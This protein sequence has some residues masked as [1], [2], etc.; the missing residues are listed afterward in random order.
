MA[1]ERGEINP[2]A[3]P[4]APLDRAP[5]TPERSGRFLSATPA[6]RW[7][8]GIMAVVVLLRVLETANDVY[9]ISL[10]NRA[11]AGATLEDG[12]ISGLNGRASAGAWGNIIAALAAAVLFCVFM[13]RA[14]RNARALSDERLNF[15]PGWAAGVFFVPIWNLYKPYQAMKELWQHSDPAGGSSWGVPAPALVGWWW[16]LYLVSGGAE[17]VFSSAFKGTLPPDQYITR[18]EAHIVVSALATAAAVSAALV[19]RAVARR[20]DERA[21]A[22][23]AAG[24]VPASPGVLPAGG[25]S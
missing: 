13:P 10:M 20:Q 8:V 1:E 14:N 25:I 24:A 2:Y 4:Q 11:I 12:E 9:G 17:R 3:A 7:I 23:P 16:G 21:A 19:V 15:T 5:A 6:A 18:C 22:L